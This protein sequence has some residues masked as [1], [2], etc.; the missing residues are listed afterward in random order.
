[1]SIKANCDWCGTDCNRE[2]W[3]AYHGDVNHDPVLCKPCWD[4]LQGAIN[5]ASLCFKADGKKVDG[6]LVWSKP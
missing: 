3:N 4:E 2:F 6:R 5:Y 1:M